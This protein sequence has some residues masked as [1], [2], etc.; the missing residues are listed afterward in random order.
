MLYVKGLDEKTQ[1]IVQKFSECQNSKVMVVKVLSWKGSTVIWTDNK[2]LSKIYKLIEHLAKKIMCYGFVNIQDQIK[3]SA[4]MALT[5][6]TGKSRNCWVVE[7]SVSHSDKSAVKWHQRT[8]TLDNIGHAENNEVHS[9]GFKGRNLANRGRHHFTSSG[10]GY[11]VDSEHCN[12][13]CT[14]KSVV[15]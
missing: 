9:E 8:H 13:E 11:L 14:G 2:N 5:L 10:L 7:A 6:W 15:L 3:P 1:Q 12:Q 4:I